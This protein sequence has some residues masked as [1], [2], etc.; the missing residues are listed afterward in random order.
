M[1]NINYLKQIGLYLVLFLAVILLLQ[2]CNNDKLQQQVGE[3][4]ILKEQLESKTKELDLEKQKRAEEKDSL[5]FQISQRETANII[6]EK[7]VISLKGT[8][9]DIKSR[10][11]K[12]PKGLQGLADYFNEEF[13]TNENIVIDGKVGLGQNTA[14]D[15]TWELEEGKKAIEIL[16]ILEEV[17]KNQEQI[18]ENQAKDKADLSTMLGSAEEEIKKQEELQETAEENIK[19]LEKQV[20]KQK[21]KNFWNK[22]LIGV[23]TIGGFLLGSQ[24]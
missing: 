15:V 2:K 14:T 11:N 10:P 23:G 21:N 16:P 24:L 12:Q 8:I 6:L 1:K 20:K 7:E 17:N 3:Y 9:A 13:E 4:K 18:I 5:N 22:V 19:V